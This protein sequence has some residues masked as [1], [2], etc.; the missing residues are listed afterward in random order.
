VAKTSRRGGGKVEKEWGKGIREKLK[1]DL[2][3]V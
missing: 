3:F 2:F 1:L